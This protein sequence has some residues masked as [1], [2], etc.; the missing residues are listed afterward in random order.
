M[1]MVVS[2]C[3]GILFLTDSLQLWQA[4]VLLVVH[5]LAGCLWGPA[6]QMMLHDFVD[7]RELPSAVRLHATFRSLGILFGPV[8]GSALLLGFGPTWGIFINIVFYLPLTLFLI[9]T[10]FTGHLRSGGVRTARTTLLASLKVLVEVRHNRSIIGMLLLAALASITIGA[11]LQ[12][13][14][15]VFGG[16]LTPTGGDSDFTYGVLLFAMRAGGELGGFALEAAGWI[17]AAAS[18][19]AVAAG[20]MGLSE[21]GFGDGVE[22]GALRSHRAA[23]VGDHHA[24]AGRGLEDHRRVDRDGDHPTRGPHRDPRPCHR[25]L[26]DVRARHADL[27][28][29]HRRRARHDRDDPAGRRHRRHHPGH[30]GHGHRRLRRD[31]KEPTMSGQSLD[32]VSV[33]FTPVKGTRHVRRPEA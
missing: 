17:Q 8:V 6:E 3:W 5:G 12:T 1:F 26:C 29:S 19:A 27:L 11:V 21:V 20:A 16:I 9:R 30:R 14:M 33:G 22:R 24:P 4:C 2:L 23:V 13:A 15:P 7:R 28:R 10:P 32:V 18:A 31:R 25:V